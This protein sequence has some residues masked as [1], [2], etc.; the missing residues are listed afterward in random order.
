MG[1]DALPGRLALPQTRAAAATAVAIVKNSKHPA[2][3][4]AEANTGIPLSRNHAVEKGSARSPR[5]VFRALAARCPACVAV[6]GLAVLASVSPLTTAAAAEPGLAVTFST[7]DGRVTDTTTA[8]NICLYV[9]TGHPPTPFVPPGP[10]TAVWRGFISAELRGTFLFQA[11]LSGRFQLEI[12]GL[13]ALDSTG[14][15]GASPLSRPVKLHKGTN[16]FQATFTSP[17]QDDAFVRLGWTEQGTNTSPIP[18]HVFTHAPTPELARAAERYLGRELFFERRCVKCHVGSFSGN[19]APE[20]KMDAPSL[21]GI[22]A[23]RRFDWMAQWVL[24][25]KSIRPTAHM[26]TLLRGP[27]AREDA[28]AVAAYLASQT[29]GPEVKFP[30]PFVTKQQTLGE[31]ESAA[32]TGEAKPIYERLHCAVCHNPPDA[33][34]IDPKKLSQKGVGLKFPRGRLAEFLRAPE[35]HYAWTSMPN[36]RLSAAEAEELEDYLLGASDKPKEG[37]A[38]ADAALIERGRKLVQTTGCLNC[39]ALNLENQFHA[40]KL[41]DLD[42]DKLPRAAGQAT[43]DVDVSRWRGGCLAATRDKPSRAPQFGFSDA[44]RDA[45]RTFAQA[46]ARLGYASLARHVPAEFAQR[47]TRSLNC[48]ACHGQIDLVPPLEILGGKLKPEWSAKFL[49]G[50]IHHK[51]RY[52]THPRGEPWLEARMPAF[53]TQGPWL[54]E[55]LAGGHGYGPNTPAEPPVNRDLAQQGQKL[56]G[57]DG[58]FSCV[59]CHA[60]GPLPALEVFESEGPNLASAAERLLPDYFRRWVRNPLAIDPQTKMPVYF[61][62][63]GRSP[64][65]EILGG[66]GDKQLSAIWEYLRLGDQMPAPKAAVE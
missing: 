21:E 60:V 33:T 15:G 27:S 24:D 52:D 65:S 8:P 2:N 26:P 42:G 63:E 41:A 43:A 38:P 64:L 55:G 61:D 1:A 18:N 4:P 53:K 51:I 32:P 5:A 3:S 6:L 37:P 56:V 34:E 30:A 19:G 17:A 58:G 45:L 14:T 31:G 57:K 59:S 12:N 40:P 20:L 49:A 13:V 25:P 39:H 23:R 36:F 66:N 44:E 16:T 46:E 9:Q 28:R 47:Q 22:G 10:F 54:A 11:Q 35:A 50:E 48:G 62:E 7:Q 29:N